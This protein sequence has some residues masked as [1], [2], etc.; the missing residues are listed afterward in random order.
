MATDFQEWLA[1]HDLGYTISS[2]DGVTTVLQG[3]TDTATLT[4]ETIDIEATIHLGSP[5]AKDNLG[6]GFLLS[7]FPGSLGPHLQHQDLHDQSRLSGS[8]APAKV[9]HLSISATLESNENVFP[10]GISAASSHRYAKQTRCLV[11]AEDEKTT[12]KTNWKCTSVPTPQQSDPPN[13]IGK[14]T[15]YMLNNSRHLACDPQNL[16]TLGEGR[17]SSDVKNHYMAAMNMIAMK[18]C[19]LHHTN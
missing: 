10:V 1:Y 13:S 17:R 4:A 2:V 16:I 6:I 9:I 7:D 18:T 14:R 3:G 5:C 19:K 15:L 12:K 8:R 11:S